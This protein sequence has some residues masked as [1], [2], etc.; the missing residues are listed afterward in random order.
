MKKWTEFVNKKL[1]KRDK[2]IAFEES[3]Q[4]LWDAKKLFEVDAS[5]SDGK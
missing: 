1:D 2:L 3:S 5:D 4:K